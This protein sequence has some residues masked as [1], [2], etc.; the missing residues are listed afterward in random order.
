[1]ATAQIV[2]AGKRS[3]KEQGIKLPEVLSFKK[4][5]VRPKPGSFVD[6]MV[7]ENRVQFVSGE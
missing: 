1:M 4:Y 3:L 5:G 6:K 2:N 7:K